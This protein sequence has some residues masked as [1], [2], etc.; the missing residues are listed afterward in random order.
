MLMQQASRLAWMT[1][2]LGVL[3][4]PAY[5]Q[6]NSPQALEQRIRSL[7]QM[8]QEQQ[9]RVD[10]LTRT[11]AALRRRVATD[12]L[13][14]APSRD[15]S[16]EDVYQAGVKLLDERQFEDAVDRFQTLLIRF[17]TGQRAAEAHFWL[18][19]IY[20]LQDLR[21]EAKQEFELIVTM[22]ENHWRTPTAHFK[23]GEIARVSADY[24]TARE[25]YGTVISRYPDSPAAGLASLAMRSLTE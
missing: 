12:E 16:E 6:D 14:V 20:F 10:T 5:A 1:M 9:Q 4:S 3:L 7:E 15:A 17:P 21:Q 23:L 22:Y 11:V 13:Q 8:V 2:G 24:V 18:G 19:E 25:Q